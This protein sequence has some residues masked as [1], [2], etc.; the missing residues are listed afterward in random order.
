MNRE[1]TLA[2][3]SPLITT[4]WDTAE[5]L[6]TPDDMAAYLEATIQENDPTLLPHALAVLARAR[7][8]DTHPTAPSPIDL[9]RLLQTSSD[10]E[11]GFVLKIINALG[12]EIHILPMQ[13]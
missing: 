1:L 13:A 12:L 5:F 6:H 9:D 8:L 4:P 10:L 7:G 2:D 11:F 3:N